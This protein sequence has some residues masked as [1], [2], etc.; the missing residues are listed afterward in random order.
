MSAIADRL[1]PTTRARL[2]D[3]LT[4]LKRVDHLM[5]Q[6]SEQRPPEPPPTLADIATQREDGT[7]TI[8]QLAEPVTGQ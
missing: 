7:V 2:L 6:P 5:R 4:E 3:R 8:A 1:D